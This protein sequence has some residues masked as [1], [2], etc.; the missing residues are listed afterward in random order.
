MQK[1]PWKDF[2][3]LQIGPRLKEGEDRE[4]AGR[5]PARRVAGS[6]GQ[7]AR[8]QERLEANLWVLVARLEVADRVVVGE[9]VRAAAG[10]LV[11]G[12]APAE[13]RQV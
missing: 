2:N 11:G 5:I 3:P 8:K 10:E 1:E 4:G 12:C 13:I 9:E 6:E 7:G